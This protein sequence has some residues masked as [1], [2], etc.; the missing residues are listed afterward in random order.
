M[1]KH[2]TA[3]AWGSKP[4]PCRPGFAWLSVLALL[5]VFVLVA[6]TGRTQ[7]PKDVRDGGVE[8]DVSRTAPIRAAVS[9]KTVRPRAASPA[10]VGG[11]LGRLAQGLRLL[12]QTDTSRELLATTWAELGALPP[13]ERTVQILQF[14]ESGEDATT[15]M[16]FRV[17]SGG[18]LAESPSVRVAALDWLGQLDPVAAADYAE[19]IFEASNSSDEWAVA[20]RNLGRSPGAQANPLFQ[21]S[22]RQLI[23]REDWRTSPTRG[24]AEALDSVVLLGDLSLIPETLKA[25]QD[26]PDIAPLIPVVLDNLILGQP[27]TALPF[28][29][30][31][32]D[33]F[34]EETALRASLVARADVRDPAQRKAVE[35]YLLEVNASSEELARF[36]HLFPLFNRFLGQHLMTVDQP[37]TIREQ[38]SIDDAALTAVVQWK[39]DSRFGGVASMLDEVEQRLRSH[40]ESARRSGL[41]PRQ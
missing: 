19:H 7:E 16:E 15:G 25:A 14:L 32:A 1:E 40:V 5:G 11:L 24:Y 30:Q 41:L 33:L 4:T 38:A 27:S 26:S 34:R 10:L 22:V 6:R 21:Q 23:V 36:G 35:D 13:E 17:A 8:E 29:T 2:A 9:A 12:P 39:G 3:R 31:D 18:V 28:L 20:L 37:C